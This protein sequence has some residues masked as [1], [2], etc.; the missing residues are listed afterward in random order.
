MKAKNA[1]GKTIRNYR[2]PALPLMVVP[3]KAKIQEEESIMVCGYCKGHQ[4]LGEA[5]PFRINGV[6]VHPDH[7][8]CIESVKHPLFDMDERKLQARFTGIPMRLS[9]EIKVSA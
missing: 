3:R 9:S 2:N 8:A 6:R 1:E 4:T 7:K 5:K